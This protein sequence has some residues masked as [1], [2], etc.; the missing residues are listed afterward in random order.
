MKCGQ[1]VCLGDL[2]KW[3]KS[4][5]TRTGELYC[6]VK[7]S[8]STIVKTTT[9]TTITLRYPHHE[10]KVRKNHHLGKELAESIFRSHIIP[11]HHGHCTTLLG[12]G[13]GSC[14]GSRVMSGPGSCRVRLW[15]RP[16]ALFVRDG[17][18]RLPT[19]HVDETTD[20]DAGGR[21]GSR[22]DST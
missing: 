12:S 7:W 19:S 4:S 14:V 5:Q 22:G 18:L 2:R 16:S 15:C 11:F 20:S 9:T 17:V 10:P 1:A 6:L 13:P 8:H 21:P 3:F